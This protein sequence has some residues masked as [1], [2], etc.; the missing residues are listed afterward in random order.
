M[1]ER[2]ETD[3]CIIG[4]GSGGLSVAAGA[5]QMGARCVLIEKD[6]MGGDCLNYGCV[7][8][9]SLLAAAHAAHAIAAGA[10]FGVKASPP[11]VDFAKVNAH[12]HDVI[13]GIAPHDSVERFEGLGVTVLR[14]AAR[15]T[16]PRELAA[17]DASVR[18]RRF[19]I[20]TGSRPLVPP[21]PGIDTVPYL[22]NET[23]FGLTEAPPKL[24][25][26]GGGPIGLE[27]AQAH[28]R[29]GCEV[30]V[31]EAS[32]ILNKD[33]PELVEVVRRRLV[34]EG[35][36]LH[37]ETKVTAVAPAGAGLR[38]HF[39]RDGVTGEVDGS[40]LLLAVGRAANVEDLGLE[41]AGVAYS[42]RGIEV[43]ARLRTSNKRIFAVG[44]VA[45]GYQFT[46]VANYHAGIV[47]RNALFRLPAKADHSAVPWVT[48]TDPEL[49]H[50]GMSAADASE[51]G[52]TH[53]VLRAPLDENDRARTERAED[54]IVKA[55][56]GK[57][58]RVLGASIVG[59]HAGELIL[60][61]VFA[62]GGKL[63]VKDLAS[64]IAPY[65]T[66]SEA[67]KRAAGSYFTPSL[68]S[69]RTRWLVRLLQR[70]G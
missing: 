62:V 38:L 40:H 17:G 60:P 10:R 14:D 51:Q 1:A 42:R 68:F 57:R 19:V 36:G 9:K 65:P 5:A 31:L 53:T 56:V 46:H 67:S 61:W 41:E 8:S 12:V 59:P 21:I 34:A 25:I 64:V 2:I 47:I 33:D 48:Y 26:V 37:E 7:P 11:E 24:I 13:A 58:G 30:E 50:V 28:R 55:V 39:E 16:G 69:E 44:D 52:L 18:A 29:L 63:R 20:A 3:L 35:I 27:M 6:K 66:L 43:D 49:A 23:V 70:L 15:F 54:G 32:G 22:T 4:G 45:G